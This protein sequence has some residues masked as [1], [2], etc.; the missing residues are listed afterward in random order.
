M[1]VPRVGDDMS[2][3]GPDNAVLTAAQEKEI[4]RELTEAAEG[5]VREGDTFYLISYRW[6]LSLGLQPRFGGVTSYF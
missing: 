2:V 5:Q 1:P 4:V 3:D 6:L